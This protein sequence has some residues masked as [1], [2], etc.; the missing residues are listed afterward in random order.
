MSEC[1]VGNSIINNQSINL[2]ILV[3]INLCV[4]TQPEL[5]S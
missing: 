4:I 1:A 2:Y 5:D 3:G